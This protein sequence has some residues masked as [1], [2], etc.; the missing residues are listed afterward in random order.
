MIVEKMLKLGF[1][2]E[3][4]NTILT[5]YAILRLRKSNVSKLVGE[6]LDFFKNYGYSDEDIVKMSKLHPQI[7]GYSATN[8]SQKI[9][10]LENLG[11]A[12]VEIIKMTKSCPQIFSLSTENIINKLEVMKGLGYKISNLLNMI[13][14]FPQILTLSNEYIVNKFNDLIGLGYTNK[15][16]I[17]IT[18]KLPQIWSLTMEN[19]TTKKEFYDSIGISSF[20][21]VKANL[22]MQSVELSYARYMFYMSIGKTIDSNNYMDIFCGQKRFETLYGKTNKDLIELYPYDKEEILKRIKK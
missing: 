14:R 19:I 9:L 10:F 2:E 22:L 8:I 11:Y 17:K 4:I 16:V 15:E 21:L 12:K 7:Y 18:I 3:Q 5:N 6:M 13:S 20:I 1:T